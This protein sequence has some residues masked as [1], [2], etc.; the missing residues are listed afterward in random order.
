MWKE[1]QTEIHGPDFKE[2]AL[3]NADQILRIPAAKAKAKPVP[4]PEAS[5]APAVSQ[6][7]ALIHE[8]T[9]T[10][11]MDAAQRIEMLQAMRDADML[12]LQAAGPE[13]AAA[14]GDEM[15]QQIVSC[16]A[17]DDLQSQAV[18]TR[19]LAG[20]RVLVPTYPIDTPG[21]GEGGRGDPDSPECSNQIDALW[22]DA[23]AQS[24]VQD[25]AVSY[26]ELTNG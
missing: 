3:R 19:G 16:H 15:A 5:A 14:V 24:L 21:G 2:Q 22:L 13:G 4:K 18:E 25:C 7:V 10:G 1:I 26:T 12:A 23:Q 17:T 20:G 11:E 6:S 8:R 9:R